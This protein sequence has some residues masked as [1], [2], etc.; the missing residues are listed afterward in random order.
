MSDR[1]VSGVLVAFAVFSIIAAGCGEAPPTEP[2]KDA[3]CAEPDAELAKQLVAHCRERLAG[4]AVPRRVDFAPRI[5]RTETG[6]LA[7][8]AI[9]ERVRAA[10]RPAAGD[11]TLA[12]GL[13]HERSPR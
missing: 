4:Y 1:R 6:K 5:E 10:A 9:R 3:E 2:A 11:A 8:R 13:E 12:I 7:R